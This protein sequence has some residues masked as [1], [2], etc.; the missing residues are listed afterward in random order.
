MK[1]TLSLIALSATTAAIPLATQAADIRFNGFASV[2]AGQTLSEGTLLRATGGPLSPEDATFVADLPS[3]GIYDDDISFKPDTIFGLQISADLGSG[4]SV[5]GQITGA[6]GEDFDAN[7]AWAYISYE[8]NDAWTLVAGRQRLP[9]FFYSDFLDVGYAYHWMRA[10][11]ETQV[12]VDTLDGLQ[13]RHEGSLGSWDTRMQFYGGTSDNDVDAINDEIKLEDIVGAVFYMSNDWLQLRATHMVSEI[14]FDKL[15]ET[16]GQGEDDAVDVAFSGIAA[17]MTLGD[18]FI[19][20]EYVTYEYDDILQPFG[21]DVFGG[22]YISGGYRFG[23]FTPHITFS[24]ETQEIKDSMLSPAGLTNG[25]DS[26]DSITVGVRWDFHPQAAFK[27]E[28]QTRSEE[29]DDNIE[30]YYGDRNEVDLVSV[31]FDVIF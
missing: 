6:G 27:V 2:V 26:T 4:L 1:K 20:A 7:I 31:G 29:S 15:S 14:Y 30:A 3:D 18:G 11:I 9:F 22:G 24:T 25:D 5:T 17:H 16:V 21:W 10:P 8:F 12:I 19:V 28:Y 23:D 13:M